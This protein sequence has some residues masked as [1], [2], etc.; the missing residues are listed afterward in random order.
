EFEGTAIG[1]YVLAGPDAGTVET[2]VDGKNPAKVNLYHRYSGGLQYPRTVM[3]ATDLQEGRHVLTLKV[4]E[5]TGS[6]LKGHAI[7]VLN[8]VAN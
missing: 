8:F 5:E 2:T 7:R 1:A 6:K 3:F 4:S